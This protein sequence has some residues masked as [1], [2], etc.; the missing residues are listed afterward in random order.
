V[1]W[2]GQDKIRAMGELTGKVVLVTGGARRLGRAIALEMA[3]HGAVVVITY[4]SSNAQAEQTL[5]SLR[6]LG[7]KAIAIPCDVTDEESIQTV[8][9]RLHAEFGRLDLLVNNAA[10]FESVPFEQITV[11]QWDRMFASN[12]RSPYLVSRAALALLRKRGG[13]IINMGSLGGAQP[14]STHAHYCSSKAA[15][16]MLTEVMAKALAPE[17]AVN[18]VAPGMIELPGEPGSSQISPE[19]HL[20]FME[21]MASQTPMQSNGSAADVVAAVMF[22]ATAPRFITGQILYVDGGL[23]LT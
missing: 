3:A 7:S 11:E 15:V 8:M 13:R 17:I 20:K 19:H 21:R 5:T 12:A 18:C 4:R 16:H 23:K 1:I 6:Q 14:W 9:E 10:N 2:A 22:F